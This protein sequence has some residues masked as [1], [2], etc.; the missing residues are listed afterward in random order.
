ML[1]F[2]RKRLYK[3]SLIYYFVRVAC[4]LDSDWLVKLKSSKEFSSIISLPVEAL[5]SGVAFLIGSNTV[6]KSN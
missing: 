4:S 2:I 3:E 1:Q 5:L 6:C